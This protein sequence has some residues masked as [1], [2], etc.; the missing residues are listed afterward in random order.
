MGVK[1]GVFW[2]VD[3]VKS[4]IRR[5]LHVSDSYLHRCYQNPTL[6]PPARRLSSGGRL[7]CSSEFCELPNACVDQSER[8]ITRHPMGLGEYVLIRKSSHSEL[9]PDAT[10]VTSGS[11]SPQRFLRVLASICNT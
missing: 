4:L 7:P 1:R 2:S 10:S 3:K 8:T 6:R 9:V 11:S 5:A